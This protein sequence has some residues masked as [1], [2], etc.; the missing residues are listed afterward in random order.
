MPIMSFKF[1][2]PGFKFLLA[3]AA[4]LKLETLNLELRPLMPATVN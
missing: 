4:A 2:V 3:M 1:H